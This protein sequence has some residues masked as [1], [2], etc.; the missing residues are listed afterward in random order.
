MDKHKQHVETFDYLIKELKRM[1]V[2]IEEVKAAF[3]D[4]V[5]EAQAAEQLIA[6]QRTEITDK[7]AR[8]ASLEAGDTGLTEAEADELTTAVNGAAAGLKAAVEPPPPVS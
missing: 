4:L 6:T 5:T 7:D 3:A 1:A 2:D 8:I